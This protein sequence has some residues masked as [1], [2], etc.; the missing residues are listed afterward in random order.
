MR[1]RLRVL[2]VISMWI[3]VRIGSHGARTCGL[4]DSEL[5]LRL[6]LALKVLARVVTPQVR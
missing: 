6:V 5:G 4:V 2:H 1:V 3:E